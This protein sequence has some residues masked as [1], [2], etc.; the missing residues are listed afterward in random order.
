MKNKIQKNL[1]TVTLAISAYNEE[2]NIKKFLESVLTQKEKGFILKNIWIYNDGSTDK[3]SEIVKSFS[4]K[5]IRLFDDHKRIGKSSRLNEI[6]TR[7][8]TDILVQS[9]AD[10]IMAH[11]FVIHDLIQPLLKYTNVG[12]CGGDPLPLPGTTF[13]ERAVNCT[14]EAYLPLRKLLR[15]G[16]NIFSC[17]G[18][19]LAYKKS[20][21]KKMYIPEDMTSND[22]FTYFSCLTF[23]Y[24]YKYVS[25]ATVFYRSPKTLKDQLRQNGRFVC[26]PI[27]HVRYFPASLVKRERYIPTSIVVKNFLK[28]FKKQPIMCI[29]IF[30]INLYC[31]YKAKEYERKVTAK[32]PMAH[33]TK[34]LVMQIQ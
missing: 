13:T 20:L 16:N 29:Y 3:T 4:V 11:P 24:K 6:Y 7:L 33:S 2:H 34:S 30:L 26:S 15:G 21:V 18:R 32:W 23:G 5:K 27:R 22:K 1:P 14:V 10:V 8:T 17:D 28:Q 25:S 12:M 9:D 19:L 31:H